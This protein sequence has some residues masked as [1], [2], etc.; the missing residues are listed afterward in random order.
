MS[1]K[2]C[3]QKSPSTLPRLPPGVLKF[4]AHCNLVA[5]DPSIM[6]RRD[7]IGIASPINLRRPIFMDDLHGSGNN[8]AKV[9]R[10]T[11][12][13]TDSGADIGAPVPSGSQSQTPCLAPC[14]P[15]TMASTCALGR[16]FTSPLLGKSVAP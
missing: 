5:K 9:T 8:D 15:T 2:V 16:V 3:H 7:G 13:R 11:L 6:S 12:I 1:I 10:M 4:E 14:S